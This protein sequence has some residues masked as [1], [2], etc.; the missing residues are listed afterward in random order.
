M[1][2]GN[3]LGRGRPNRPIIVRGRLAAIVP[4]VA[5]YSP[6]ILVITSKRRPQRV[7]R[8]VMKRTRVTGAAPAYST[9]NYYFGSF[10]KKWTMQLMTERISTL[11]LEKVEISVRADA[12]GLPYDP[13]SAIA[14]MAFMAGPLL[15]PSSGDWKA[16][17]WDVTRIGTY[18]MQCRVGLGGTVVLPFGGYYVWGRLTDAA[19]GETPVEQLGRL[20]V[21]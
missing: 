18:V 14:E 13:T 1:P 15:K 5:T 12:S 8:A 9:V 11:S 10:G 4:P 7:T 19:A 6:R 17:G 2:R 16:C 20:F 3:H 21:D